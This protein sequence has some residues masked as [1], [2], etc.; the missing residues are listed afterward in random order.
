MGGNGNKWVSISVLITDNSI[1]SVGLAPVG[2]T[3]GSY[4]RKQTTHRSPSGLVPAE[5][6]HRTVS[7]SAAPSGA[8]PAEAKLYP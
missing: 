8:S 7:G 3:T 5:A 2:A 1:V 4:H 6:T